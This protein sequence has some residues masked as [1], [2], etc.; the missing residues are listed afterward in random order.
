MNEIILIM[1][2]V[3][4]IAGMLTGHPIPYVIGAVGV[5]AGY[6]G[7]W[8]DVMYQIF[9][10]K[11][12]DTMTS[13]TFLAIPLFILMANFLMY[14]EIAENLFESVRY[15]FGP[16][17]GGLA[18]AVIVVSTV[19]AAT[20]GIV[21]ASIVT[22]GMLGLPTMLKY[23]YRKEL[24]VGV[25]CAGGS[26]GVIIPPSIIIVLMG[27]YS[28]LS[29]GKLFL[30]SL[31]PGLM[32]SAGYIIYTLIACYMNP[33]YGPA[34]SAEEL[35]Q[36][37]VSERIKKSLINMV[38]PLILMGGVL[39]CIFFGVTT[40]T[41]AA[42]MGAAIA[43]VM[44]IPY[45]KFSFK[46][47]NN[48]VKNTAKTTTMVFMILIGASAFTAMFMALN[49][50]EA[51]M[52]LFTLLG[53]GKWGVLTLTLSIVFV[54]GMFMDV[55]AIIMLV[56]PIIIPIVQQYGMD[57]IWVVTTISVILQTS[58]MTPPFGYALFYIKGIVPEGVNLGHIY[59]GVVPF[60]IIVVIVTTLIMIFPQLALWLPAISFA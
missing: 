31:I 29:V 56:F 45:G 44:T 17:R 20:T 26:L 1:M 28:Q 6:A 9:A 18:V 25:V 27:V 7:G 11:I 16:I 21:G 40:P 13:F 49:G 33:E 58:Y 23:G 35:E 47:I 24:S 52:K 22:M 2:F 37:P 10:T 57:A 14:S 39:G 30:A 41:E 50:S 38:P 8:G 36:V 12:Y 5:F 15:L 34:L 46:M 3:G 54:L 42:G 59:R 55:G 48:S 53:L 51:V 32:L 60:I 43:L 19:F 4:L